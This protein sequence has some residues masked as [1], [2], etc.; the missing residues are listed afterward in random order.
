MNKT[1]TAF[2][3]FATIFASGAQA[4]TFTVS[5][6]MNSIVVYS[7]AKEPEICTVRVFFSYLKDGKRQNGQELCTDLKVV[8]GEKQEFCKTVNDELVSVRV[9]GDPQVSCQKNK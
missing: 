9:E 3:L 6:G 4:A 7:A 2:A 8:P 5:T 1:I